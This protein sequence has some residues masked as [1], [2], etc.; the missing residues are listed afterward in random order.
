M[1]QLLVVALLVVTAHADDKPQPLDMSDTADH[2]AVYRDDTGKVY[3]VP[4]V[5]ATSEQARQ[6]TFYGDGKTMYQQ[7]I[8]VFSTAQGDVALTAWSP[9]ARGMSN[10]QI[11]V[12]K[13]GANLICEFKGRHYT[14][15][16]LT[17]VSDDEAAKLLKSAKFLPALWTRRVLFFGRGDSGT[18]YLVDVIRDENGGGGERLFVGK[19]GQLKPLTVTDVA[20]DTGGTAITTKAGSLE[21]APSGE[22]IWRTGKKKLDV[23]RLDP[24]LNNYLIYRELGVYGQLGTICEDQ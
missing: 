9:R 19:K 7:H 11:E 20:E 13:T 24:A 15:K 23:Q 2:V 18:Y 16:P 10:G 8:V 22:A 12:K 1:R 3:V 5:A 17:A 14:R 21:I 6:W 4:R